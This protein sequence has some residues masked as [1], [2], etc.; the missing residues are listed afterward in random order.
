MQYRTNINKC[1]V[2]EPIW[3][4]KRGLEHRYGVYEWADGRVYK[5]S[6]KRTKCMEK[7]LIIGPMS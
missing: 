6:G 2:I 5:A 1:L 3:V 4:L 7:A